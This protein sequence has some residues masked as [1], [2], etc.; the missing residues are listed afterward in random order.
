MLLS[1]RS[2][3]FPS[4]LIKPDRLITSMRLF[5]NLAVGGLFLVIMSGSAQTKNA[6][7]P[8]TAHLIEPIQ[9]PALYIAYCAVCHG[10]DGKGG[11]PM[12]KS[13]KVAPAD[14]TRAAMRN[15]GTAVSGGHTVA[16]FDRVG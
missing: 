16:N 5:V 3:P 6:Q 7:P 4:P 9:G 14:L 13:L 2:V 10:K 11:G 12:A 8:E 15:G 1:A